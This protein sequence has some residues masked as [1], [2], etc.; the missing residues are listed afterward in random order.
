MPFVKTRV[1]LFAF[2]AASLL[3]GCASLPPGTPGTTAAAPAVSPVAQAPP[4][5]PAPPHPQAPPAPRQPVQVRGIY[6]TGYTAGNDQ[7]FSDLLDFVKRAGLNAMVIDVKDDEGFVSFAS[8]LPLA[9]EI[10]SNSD[11]IRDI[12][13]RLRTLRENNVYAIARIVVFV[14]PVLA[15]GRPE[16]GIQGGRWR[17]VRGL[18]W[19]NPYDTNVWRYNVD[20][21]KEAAKVG[22]RE[23]QFDYVRMPERSIPGVTD[24]VGMEKRVNAIADFLRYAVKELKPYDVFVSADVFGLTTS[25]SDDMKIGQDYTT[26][27]GITDY[28]SPMVYPSH[29]SLGIYGLANPEASP[30]ETVF[31]SLTR[32]QEKTRWLSPS[33]HR[34]WI[35]DFSLRVHYG[36]AEVE[37]QLRGL[38]KAGIKSFMVWDPRNRYTRDVD[39]SIIDRTPVEWHPAPPPPK[40]RPRGLVP[41]PIGNPAL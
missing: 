9:K 32:G 2:V 41:D 19:G 20:I 12:R 5:P 21:A 13:G 37:A 39:Y 35:Q 26:I 31:G 40:P 29:Y 16:W 7:R 10:G 34:P 22:F 14:D 11:K 33:H 6:L 4:G 23:I 8:D 38:A 25:V 15:R 24:G 30:L 28:I 27:A 36:R 1:T 17:D 3:A 18:A